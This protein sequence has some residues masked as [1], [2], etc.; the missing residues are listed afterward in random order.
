M[1]ITTLPTLSRTATTFKA[2]V[3]NFFG[4]QLPAFA[5][6]GNALEANVNAKE[7]TTSAA[8][9]TATTQ[10]GISTDNAVQTAADAAATASDRVQTALDR[11]S[12]T[13]SAGTASTQAGIATTKAA[14]AA[15]SAASVVRDGSGGVAG[16]TGFAV[17]I[18]NS[19]KSFKSLLSFAG[20]T[21]DRAHALPDKSGMLALLSD[22]TYKTQTGSVTITQAASNEMVRT[23]AS[24]AVV[25]P[26]AYLDTN[27][28]VVAE[29]ESA[30]PFNGSAGQVEVTNRATN[31]FAL[32]ITGS[33]T[34]ATLRWKTLHPN[35]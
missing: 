13:T 29:I 24:A 18:W 33:A 16:L 1:P 4:T 30:A 31:G 23:Y 20:L 28:Q 35:A 9:V 21:A 6:E 19:A 7:V 11:A 10:A 2:D 3:D 5:A 25:L 32:S 27:Y 15:A 8:A 26:I 14:E 17:N 22:L 12:A 34:S